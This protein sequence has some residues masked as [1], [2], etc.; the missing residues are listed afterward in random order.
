MRHSTLQCNP[1]NRKGSRRGRKT[2]AGISTHNPHPNERRFFADR[3]LSGAS[4]FRLASTLLQNRTAVHERVSQ[5]AQ[6]AL[7][8][9]QPHY[10][11]G[12]GDS[13]KFQATCPRNGGAV[14][15]GESRRR[16]LSSRKG[17]D[18][19]SALVFFLENGKE[20][21]KVENYVFGRLSIGGPSFSDNTLLFGVI[22]LP[23]WEKSSAAKTTTPPCQL[24][25]LHGSLGVGG[26]N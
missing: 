11:E 4:T 13:D 23:G 18:R 9:L 3:I 15:R 19:L 26:G 17:C 8:P 22:N 14:L 6:S 21:A 10:C 1:K 5:T 24:H 7:T 16:Q 2:R 25:S 20:G 12:T